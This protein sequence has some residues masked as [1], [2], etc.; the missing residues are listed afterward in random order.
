MAPKETSTSQA[1]PTDYL[2]RVIAL[3]RQARKAESI[4]DL[5]FI[6]VNSTHRLLPYY[7]AV[8]CEFQRSG[9]PVVAAVSGV[10][11]VDTNTPFALWISAF[12]REMLKKNT[13]NNAILLTR[14]EAEA[15]IAEEWQKWLPD[16]LLFCPLCD[17]NG[18]HIALLLLSREQPF[19]PQEKGLADI[20]LETYAHAWIALGGGVRRQGWLPGKKIRRY[21]GLLLLGLI[22]AGI[23]I[24]V[25]ETALAPGEIV[26]AA[27][28]I[29][30]SPVKGQIKDILVKPYQMVKKGTPLFTLDDTEIVNLLALTEKNLEVLKADSLRAEQKAFY[31]P[32]SKGDLEV[33]RLRIEEKELELAY[34][35]EELARQQV[36]AA[37][38]GMAIFQ[39]ANDWVG[40][41]VGIGERVM[42]L[43]NPDLAEIEIKLP[44]D[45]AI[46]LNPGAKV[47]LFLRTD[48]LN[49]IAAT[50]RRTSYKAEQ[51]EKGGMFFT[52][53]AAFAEQKERPRIGL[54]GTAKV[55]GN[56]VPLLYYLLRKPLAA[57]RR[58]LGV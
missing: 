51:S 7:Q 49:P 10:V 57:I 44:V 33:Y 31:D 27:P 45:D 19:L 4:Q 26:P 53:K 14:T 54:Q 55:Y 5:K 25:P 29:V 8:L 58:N 24:R 48:P 3:E 36:T 9:K 1:Q 17:K 21:I 38:G 28:M 11:S 18:K 35:K 41:P 37:Q 6:M 50:I 46:A 20:L 39:D 42:V 16:Y 2:T 15:K 32:Q 56:S 23:I 30:T 12:C 52:I 43:A 13:E 47:K 22:A 40:R 34:Y